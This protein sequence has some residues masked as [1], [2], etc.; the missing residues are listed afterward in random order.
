MKDTGGGSI[1]K[2]EMLMLQYTLH[3]TFAAHVTG[4]K[5]YRPTVWYRTYMLCSLDEIY[6]FKR[7][8]FSW[9]TSGNKLE[10]TWK[11]DAQITN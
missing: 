3:Q 9:T 7:T 8:T 11:T 2:Y 6:R 5:M 1:L 10:P 4:V